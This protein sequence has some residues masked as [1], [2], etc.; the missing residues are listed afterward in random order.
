MKYLK[1]TDGYILNDLSYFYSISPIYKIE[2]TA[3]IFI[4]YYKES[5][6]FFITETEKKEESNDT[7]DGGGK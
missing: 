2:N 7:E 1:V 4:A 5:T 6:I 3:Q